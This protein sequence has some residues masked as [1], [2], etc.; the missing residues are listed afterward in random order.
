MRAIVEASPD[1]RPGVISMAHAWGAAAGEDDAVD[2]VGTSTARLIDNARDYDPISGIPL[3][4][5]IPVNVRPL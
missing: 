2:G 3:Q 4:S 1:V 5:A